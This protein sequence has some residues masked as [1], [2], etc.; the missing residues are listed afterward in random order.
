MTAGNR[1]HLSSDL[2]KYMF[3]SLMEYAPVSFNETHT[4]TS[5]EYETHSALLI[6]SRGEVELLSDF[7]CE[8][9]NVDM[10]AREEAA[11]VGVVAS[12]LAN[13]SFHPQPPVI[14]KYRPVA[15]PLIQGALPNLAGFDDGLT[16]TQAW[17]EQVRF[18][19]SLLDQLGLHDGFHSVRM[20]DE[21]AE[22][23]FD[24]QWDMSCR[25]PHRGGLILLLR[26]STSPPSTMGHRTNQFPAAFGGAS[27]FTFAFHVFAS[28][29]LL[30][31][32]RSNGWRVYASQV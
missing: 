1:I 18:T 30:H 23:R 21:R 20:P 22:A 9:F 16:A 5:L 13:N 6:N 11:H 26:R 15:S 7:R 24:L 25:A 10:F 28:D 12:V 14:F 17:T 31:H 29:Q 4:N 27:S 2:V 8:N 19:A 3:E 32:V